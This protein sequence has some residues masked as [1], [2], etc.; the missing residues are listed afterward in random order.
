MGTIG[1]W[2]RC[3]SR[4]RFTIDVP[5][6]TEFHLQLARKGYRSLIYSG[7]HD[8]IIPYVGTLEWIQSLNFRI[9]DEWRPWLLKNQVAGYTRT[10]SDPRYF[11]LM[12]FATVK[13]G[14]HTAPEYKPPE[15]FAM[16]QRWITGKQL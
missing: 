8:L 12:T 13:G 3:S 14:G 4:L 10:Y 15:C 9:V 6:S 5:S 7:D 1:T 11:N 16:F 2:E